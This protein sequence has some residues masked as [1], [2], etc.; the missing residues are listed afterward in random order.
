VPREYFDLGLGLGL[1]LELSRRRGYIGMDYVDRYG[2]RRLRM[3]VNPVSRRSMTG[4]AS[5]VKSKKHVC[6]KRKKEA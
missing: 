3:K 5:V 1:E 2:M 6:S 4:M